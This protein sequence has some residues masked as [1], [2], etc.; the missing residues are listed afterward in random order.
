M[1]TPNQPIARWLDDQ[2]A[3]PGSTVWIIWAIGRTGLHVEAV[4][5]NFADVDEWLKQ[6]ESPESYHFSEWRVI[7]AGWPSETR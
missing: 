2:Q 6:Q 3:S 1:P 5:A 4:L 7:G